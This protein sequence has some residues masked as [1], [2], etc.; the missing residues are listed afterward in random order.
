MR[1]LVDTSAFSAFKRGNAAVTKALQEADEV[2]VPVMALGELSAG[3]AMGSH[4]RKNERELQEFLASPSV[5]VQD[6]DLSVAQRYGAVV[7]AMRLQGTP[8]Q[9]NDLWIAACALEAGARILSL[10]EHFEKVP[11]M[12]PV[13]L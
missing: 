2:I 11:G 12:H 9:T 10:D 8:I 6:V 3:F 1:I 7:K 5:R 13:P 4:T